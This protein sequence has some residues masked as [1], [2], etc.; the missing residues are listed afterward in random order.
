MNDFLLRINGSEMRV[1]A[2][3]DESL[4]S[5]LRNR[6]HLTGTK[7][8]CGEGQCAACTV[9]IDGQPQRSCLT[10]VSSVAHA[11][12]T[13]IE[14]LESSGALSPV[15][16]AFL[17]EEAFQCGYCTPGMVLA[18]TALLREH[19]HPSEPEIVKGMDGNVCR[20]GTYPRI[21]AAVKRAAELQSKGDASHAG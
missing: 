19:P 15:Q 13:T 21:V 8:G 4:L 14:G 11:R 9:L 1:R 17:E 2:P 3:G 16:Q 6:L 12:I 7:Y 10:Q 18:A 20:C 5:V